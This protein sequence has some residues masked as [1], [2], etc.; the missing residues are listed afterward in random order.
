M[1]WCMSLVHRTPPPSRVS[2]P[3]SP[4][5]QTLLTNL[6]PKHASTRLASLHNSTRILSTGYTISYSYTASNPA[7]PLAAPPHI[8]PSHAHECTPPS[9]RLAQLPGGGGG[10]PPEQHWRG[11]IQVVNGLAMTCK[12]LVW[13]S[14]EGPETATGAYGVWC[15]PAHTVHVVNNFNFNFNMSLPSTTIGQNSCVAASSIW[16]RVLLVACALRLS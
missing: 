2:P 3:S 5:A 11:W 12:F 15:K 16:S 7:R 6:F 9:P 13:H 4:H 1:T 14:W 8:P 10:K